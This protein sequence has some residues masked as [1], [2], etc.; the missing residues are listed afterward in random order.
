MSLSLRLRTPRNFHTP[1]SFD[2]EGYLA[3]QGI[4]LS[5]FLWDD[6]GI[7]RTGAHGNRLRAGIEQARRT[8]GAFFASE[9]F[10]FPIEELND[11]GVGSLVPCDIE[12]FPMAL[13]TRGP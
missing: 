13:H 6:S 3:R 12:R 4:Y 5:A 8:I 9:L 11:G 10:C 2:Y 7:S 1:G